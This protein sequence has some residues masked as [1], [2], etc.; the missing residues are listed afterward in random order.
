MKEYITIEAKDLKI[1]DIILNKE[2]RYE[3][4]IIDIKKID[5]GLGG[6]H[7]YL[8]DENGNQPILSVGFTSKFDKVC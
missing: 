6:L 3:E 5:G 4:T 2:D 8:E 7:L 1:G